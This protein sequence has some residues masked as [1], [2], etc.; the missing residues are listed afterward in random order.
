[1]QVRLDGCMGPIEIAAALRVRAKPRLAPGSGNM[2][3]SLPGISAIICK[4]IRDAWNRA[5]LQQ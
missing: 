2:L 4:S 3:G 1:M 5:G